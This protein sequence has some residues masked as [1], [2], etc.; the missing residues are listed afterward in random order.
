MD[1]AARVLT[2]NPG[3]SSLKLALLDAGGTV[4]H[5]L[6][7]P[8]GDG[9]READ[10]LAGAIAGWPRPGAVGLRFVHGGADL[11]HP[12]VVDEAVARR[13][14][15]LADLAPL[16]QPQSLYALAEIRRA[17]PG[18]PVVACFDTAFHAGLPP[19]ASTYAIPAEWRER[20][21]LRRYGFHGLSHAHASR[22]GAEL[23]GLDPGTARLVVC[24]LGSG[25]SLAA[26][27][28]GR[29]VDTT[30]GFTPLDGLVMAT[31]PGA[32][33][34]GVP[35]WLVRHGVPA[36]EVEDA[37]AHRSGLRGLAGTGDL[38]EVRERAEEGD[39]AALAALDVFHHRLRG[40]AAAMAA[41]LG[42]PDALVF[43]GGIGE[44]DPATR[45]RLAADLAHLGVA[46]DED[47]NAAARGDADVGA[48]GARVRAA[49]VTAREDLEIAAGTRAALATGRPDAPP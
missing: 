22:R 28:G 11:V 38:R 2:V 8:A 9:D 39:A 47:A 45:R 35:L 24:H 36:A 33:D 27:E 19:A 3:S 16:H 12:V 20:F 40:C 44:H 5:T 29:S 6:D 7:A 17:L 1:A 30:M 37:L 10:R 46:L 48:P 25:S 41:S 49:V 31:R 15:D 21:G 26:V 4:L 13:L 14:Q 18:V 43:T 32:L 34:P 42:G 23:L